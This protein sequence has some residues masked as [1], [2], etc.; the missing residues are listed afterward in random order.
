MFNTIY[1]ACPFNTFT[2]G[3]ELAHQ[4]CHAL[5]ELNYDARILYYNAMCEF[6]YWDD[7]EE[8]PWGQY[9]TKQAHYISPDQFAGEVVVLPETALILSFK[10][11]DCRKFIWWMSVDNYKISIEDYNQDTKNAIFNFI[12]DKETG[13][14]LQSYYAY[15]YCVNQ[16]GIKEDML[17]YL[18]DYINDAYFKKL[19]PGD[20]RKNYIF[21]NPKKGR[22]IT[23]KIVSLYPD[24]QWVPLM[25][26]SLDKMVSVLGTGKVYID[27]GNHPGKDRIPREAVTRGCCVLTNRSGAAY[28]DVDIPIPEKY[29]WD[30]V[31]ENIENI[32]AL[33]DDILSDYPAHFRD[34][35]KYR[36]SIRHEKKVFQ[37]QVKEFI[38]HINKQKQN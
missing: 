15:D 11:P 26:M 16:L 19:I 37:M 29:K 8:T 2:G 30:D 14:L 3:T 32:M 24:Y 33:I 4:L 17:M 5:L 9:Q 35:G 1:I 34:F 18:S 7:V 20:L 22:E 6:I 31:E 27:F 21:F 28:N 23:E 25:N 38:N 13:H 10:F 12:T 36:Q